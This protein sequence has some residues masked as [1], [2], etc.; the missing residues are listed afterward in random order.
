MSEF[1]DVLAQLR[2]AFLQLWLLVPESARGWIAGIA[3]FLLV[4]GVVSVAKH[5]WTFRYRNKVADVFADQL[6]AE[7]VSVRGADG[8]VHSRRPSPAEIQRQCRSCCHVWPAPHGFIVILSS[9][10]SDSLENSDVK[11]RLD[12]AFP[13]MTHK[14][15]SF[16]SGHLVRARRKRV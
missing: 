3:G 14:S 6:K 4:V 16:F 13:T 9:R 5:P 11:T 8:K 2:D 12:K 7:N 15:Y 10:I 1:L